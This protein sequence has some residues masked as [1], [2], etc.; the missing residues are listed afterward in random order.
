[1]SATWALQKAG[2]ALVGHGWVQ[3]GRFHRRETS[4]HQ[5][6]LEN[7]C[8]CSSAVHLCCPVLRTTGAGGL[9]AESGL[10]V[11]SDQSSRAGN[12]P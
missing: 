11:L 5:L 10:L 9:R 1:M 2:I 4:E 12:E 7:R 8:L 3:S 6:I